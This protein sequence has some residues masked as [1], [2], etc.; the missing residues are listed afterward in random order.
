MRRFR[1]LVVFAIIPL[2]TGAMSSRVNADTVVADFAAD[3]QAVIPRAGWSYQWN[4]TAPIGN[5]A[6]YQTLSFDAAHGWYDVAGNV[7][8]STGNGGFA[9][10]GRT[11]FGPIGMHPGLGTSEASDGIERFA[12]A[13]FQVSQTGEYAINNLA[14]ID[15][16]PGN[17]D[18]VD[19]YV[20]VDAVGSSIPITDG[21]SYSNPRID[22]GT[23]SAGD[24]IY[25]AVGARAVD[26]Q[27]TT[28]V[29][30]Q[31]VESSSAAPLPSAAWAGLALLICVA[32]SASRRTTCN[33]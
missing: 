12:I 29:D 7:F 20:G 5:V 18:G 14:A 8:P 25:V 28:G 19:L 13:G 6:G 22:L 16:D 1:L 27:D 10:I 31:I 24:T 17:F 26:F 11:D 4:A 3:F 2:F 32:L 21:G 33:L 23:L 9:L 30:Y 15:L